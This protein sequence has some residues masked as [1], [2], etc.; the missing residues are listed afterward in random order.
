VNKETD[1][2]YIKNK[3]AD[4]FVTGRLQELTKLKKLVL[5]SLLAL[6]VIIIIS[7]CG[8]GGETARSNGQNCVECHTDKEAILADLKANPLPVKEK[9]SESEGEG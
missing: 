1:A 8:T 9:S 7:G 3:A 5:L 2:N 4:F 6:G